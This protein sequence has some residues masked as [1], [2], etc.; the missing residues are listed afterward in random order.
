MITDV[1]LAIFA[2]MLGVAQENSILLSSAN[3]KDMDRPQNF[4]CKRVLMQGIRAPAPSRLFPITMTAS[5]LSPEEENEQL[6]PR[7]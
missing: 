5:G 2:N 1:Q 7:E 6:L 3:A 4:T